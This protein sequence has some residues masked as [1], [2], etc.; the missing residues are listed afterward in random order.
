[1]QC[2][3]CGSQ[4][5]TPKQGISKKTGRPWKAYDCN[6]PKCVNEKGYPSRTFTFSPKSPA[7]GLKVAFNEV[8]N[9][10]LNPQNTIEKKLDEILAILRQN[11]K[12]LVKEEI[13][14]EETTPF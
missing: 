4:D 9:S 11:F 3:V 10:S 12:P 14:E 13:Q 8:S 5:T 2:S 7:T 6:E 1:M